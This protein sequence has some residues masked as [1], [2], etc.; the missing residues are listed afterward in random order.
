MKKLIIGLLVLG[1]IVVGVLG[2]TNS[3][4][5]TKTDKTPAPA[6]T[7]DAAAEPAQEAESPEA[8]S[9]EEAPAEACLDRNCF[10]RFY[11]GM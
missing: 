10:A 8:Q 1:L 3:D 6:E 11:V 5:L 7:T 2:F 4:L 9:Q